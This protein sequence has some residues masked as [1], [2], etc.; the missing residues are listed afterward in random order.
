MHFEY[1]FYQQMMTFFVDIRMLEW[2][3]IQGASVILVA[4]EDV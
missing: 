3:Y 4:L 2:Y 1:R